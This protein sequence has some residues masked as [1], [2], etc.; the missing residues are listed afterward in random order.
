MLFSGQCHCGK[1][2]A[3]FETQKTP[4]EL[5]VRTCQCAF[6]RRHGAVNISDGAGRTI[7]EGSAADINRY[8]FG[9]KTADFLICKFCGTYIVAVIGEGHHIR[10]TIN[11]VGLRMSAFLD[12]EEAPMD[13]ETETTD[14]RVAR[15]F[16]K[17]TPTSF[18][19]P[20]LNASFFGPH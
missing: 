9:L 1:I 13:Y 12:V 4:Q 20:E 18:K 3:S 2:K 17:W 8:R 19:D 5:G 15:R 11:V 14:Q 10:S 16:E 7:I 6:C